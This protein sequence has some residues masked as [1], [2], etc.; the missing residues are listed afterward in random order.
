[1]TIFSE[2]IRIGT[3]VPGLF[4]SNY[5]VVINGKEYV[6]RK[7]N[8]FS[9][10]FTVHSGISF[11]S[12]VN[13][14]SFSNNCVINTSDRKRYFLNASFWGNRYQLAGQEGRLGESYRGMFS[15]SF[16]YDDRVDDSLI[17]AVMTQTYRVY[18]TATM[19]ACFVPIFVAI[20][21]SF[22]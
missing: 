12:E 22:N 6:T 1:M 13:C 8:P 19:V 21:T 2:G 16:T 17:V 9:N 7:R 14:S 3:F 10:N 4:N 20:I 18:Q 15:T 5:I 11:L